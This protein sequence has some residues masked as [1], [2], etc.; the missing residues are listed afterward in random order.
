MLRPSRRPDPV[1]PTDPELHRSL[2]SGGLLTRMDPMINPEDEPWRPADRR[3]FLRATA[4][5]VSA[6]TLLGATALAVG[7][8]GLRRCDRPNPCGECPV[9]GGCERPRAEAYRAEHAE[10]QGAN[11]DGSVAGEKGRRL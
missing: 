6:G 11:S 8:A 3:E 1:Y 9:F 7:R 4:R 10:G 2:K 5:W